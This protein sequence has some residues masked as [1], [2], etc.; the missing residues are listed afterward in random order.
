MRMNRES[1]QSA[2]NI[3]ILS[4]RS[5]AEGNRKLNPSSREEL[6]MSASD[7]SEIR[8]LLDKMQKLNSAIYQ[9]RSQTAVLDLLSSTQRYGD[10][11]YT[12]LGDMLVKLAQANM[13]AEVK[14][15]AKD[16]YNDYSK[17]VIIRTHA[18]ATKRYSTGLSIWAPIHGYEA[19]TYLP[20]YSKLSFHKATQW[21]K[22][23]ID[24][25]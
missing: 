25:R 16:A 19:K 15:I 23:F 2:R 6:T 1:D 11:D 18:S 3:G 17:Y 14:R 9:T 10:D 4:V 21:G 13:H 24:L 8:R 22:L 7:L 20:S 12:D 5:F